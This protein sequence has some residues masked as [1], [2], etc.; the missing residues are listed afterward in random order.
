MTSIDQLERRVK[1]IEQ[2]NAQ[3]TSDKSWETSAVRRGSIAVLTYFVVV[4]YLF[5][6]NNP[7]P[8]IHAIVPVL[9]YLL[10]TL[11]LARIEKIWMNKTR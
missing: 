1:A 8:F 7:S 3:V 5:F 4:V 2:R 11:A 6:I 9:G 10:S